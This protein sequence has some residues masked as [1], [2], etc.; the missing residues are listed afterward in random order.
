MPVKN[1]SRYLA[2][3]LRVIFS[4]TSL[5][6]E[7]I[8]INDGS[9]DNTLEILNLSKKDFP[10][11]RII[12]TKGIGIVKALNLGLV[13]S[14][15]EWIARFD[16][17]DMYTENRIN[18]QRAIIDDG[19]AAIF[20]DYELV[21]DNGVS[22]GV[23]PSPV[24]NLATI[25]SLLYSQQ[26]PHPGVVF[27]KNLITEA[28]GYLEDDFPA[29]DLSL[30]LRASRVGKL[31]SVPEVLLKYRISNTSTSGSRQREARSKTLILIQKYGLP[32]NFIKQNFDELS[33]TYQ[34]YS[35]LPFSIE[36]RLLFM[37]NMHMLYK[38]APKLNRFGDSS[39]PI[40]IFRNPVIVLIFIKQKLRRLVYRKF[41]F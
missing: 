15:H 31:V 27:N 17:D 19:I 38:V 30:W 32:I 4:N 12:T 21:L 5:D 16:V 29:E 33:E 2:D 25:I 11:L 39:Y 24:D 8:I 26:T 10:N 40:Y 41:N 6:D 36:R 23:I 37:R 20:C 3:S 22:T 9:T 34:N 13:E 35:K 7:V 28:G 14:S 18:K 1:G